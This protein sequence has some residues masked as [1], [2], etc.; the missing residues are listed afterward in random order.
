MIPYTLAEANPQQAYSNYANIHTSYHVCKNRGDL[1]N[2]LVCYI[3]EFMFEFCSNKYGHGITI[4]SYDNFCEK[5]WSMQD[6][7]I[8]DVPIFEIYY[9]ENDE[10]K[11]WKTNE[12]EKEIFEEY[13]KM[14][15]NKK[16]INI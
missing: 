16:N 4:T 1:H 5:W 10:W 3:V 8:I 13:M 9:F 11:E 15:D 2:S 14:L 6:R 7:K 12:Y